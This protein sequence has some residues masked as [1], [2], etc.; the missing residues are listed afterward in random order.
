MLVIRDE[1]MALLARNRQGRFRARLVDH[2]CASLPACSE[3]DPER[4]D[5]EVALGIA[6]ALEY[7]L[8][9]EVDVARYVEILYRCCE[10]PA[11]QELPAEALA[12]LYTYGIDPTLKLDRFQAW[13][14]AQSRTAE[15]A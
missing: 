2:L 15:E 12:I 14:D 3:T 7:R 5:D 9:R 4:L 13:A 1:Q 11:G 6:Q 10:G 8:R